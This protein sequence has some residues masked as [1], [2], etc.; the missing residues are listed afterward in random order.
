[1]LLTRG[2]RVYARG[3]NGTPMAARP[4]G[5]LEEFRVFR[6]A[7]ALRDPITRAVLGYE[8]QYLGKAALVR[9]DQRSRPAA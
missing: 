6:N 9:G 4:T 7:V 5:A 8:A 3:S 2:D 1:V